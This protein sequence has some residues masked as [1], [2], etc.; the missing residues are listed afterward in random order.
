MQKQKIIIPIISLILGL[1]FAWGFTF[2]SWTPLASYLA[3]VILAVFFLGM[4]VSNQQSVED[5][6]ARFQRIIS[7]FLLSYVFYFRLLYAPISRFFFENL[8]TKTS[9]LSDLLTLFLFLIFFFLFG[10]TLLV[11]SSYARFG[12]L[13]GWQVFNNSRA[14]YVL[15]ILFFTML[16]VFAM[17]YVRN[18]FFSIKNS[19]FMNKILSPS[20]CNWTY[21]RY[22]NFLSTGKEK[23]GREVCL[24]NYA[25]DRNDVKY[26]DSIF[27]PDVKN[28]CLEYFNPSSNVQE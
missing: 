11:L 18:S 14:Y 19:S 17:L 23:T 22:N 15:R 13:S 3:Y 9:F 25:Q 1:F 7:A 4:L 16:F 21:V 2:F 5:N 28:Q 10:T 12:F 8:I 20:T 24:Y 26:C 6:I 27:D